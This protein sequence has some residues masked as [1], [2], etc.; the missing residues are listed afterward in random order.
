[1]PRVGTAAST[2]SRAFPSA[3]LGSGHRI[4]D[5]SQKFP[6][7]SRPPEA[8]WPCETH[9]P[10]ARLN[11]CRRSFAHPKFRTDG[12]AHSLC[13]R[14]VAF[15]ERSAG[16]AVLCSPAVATQPR[17]SRRCARCMSASLRAC[18]SWPVRRPC[19]RVARYRGEVGGSLRVER[20]PPKGRASLGRGK[21]PRDVS[22]G[23]RPAAR[24]E[25][26]GYRSLRDSSNP[27]GPSPVTLRHCARR[28]P[29]SPRG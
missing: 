11:S 9:R 16:P 5:T 21:R 13:I 17:P 8:L 27:A 28:R 10:P 3:L 29:S 6:R 12:T 19:A 1:M 24:S 22:T 15:V 18:A 25:G 20:N 23:V 4:E 7:D 14:C 2:I 26:S